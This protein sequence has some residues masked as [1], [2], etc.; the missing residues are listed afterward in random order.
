M[1]CQK[2]SFRLVAKLA[3]ASCLQGSNFSN[4]P[5]RLAIPFCALILPVCLIGCGDGDDLPNRVAITVSV[6]IGGQT[7]GDGSLVLRPEPGV[8]CPLIKIPVVQGVGSLDASAGPVPGNYKATYRPSG[9]TN[10]IGEKLSESGRGFPVSGGSAAVP[11]ANPPAS[12][13][14]M[15][16]K[17][18]ISVTIPNGNSA[19]VEAAFEAA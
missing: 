19:T 16:P 1:T 6:K 18:P 5:M 8:K 15:S 12:F 7:V 4:F 17:G 10:N 2:V 3:Y 9:A 11:K 14:V 13:S